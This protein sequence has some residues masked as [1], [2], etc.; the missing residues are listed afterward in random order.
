MLKLP[1]TAPTDGDPL[2][3]RTRRV[4]PYVEDRRN[5]LVLKPA[6]PVSLV[7]MASLQSALK[8]AI[9]VYFQLEDTEAGRGSAAR[10]DDRRHILL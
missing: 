9:Q 4:I 3:Q 10:S 6:G 2:S 1:E 5:S 7:L 8:G